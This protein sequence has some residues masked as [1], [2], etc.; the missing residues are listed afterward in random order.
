VYFNA[1]TVSLY[2]RFASKTL[3]LLL[4]AFHRQCQQLEPYFV[5]WPVTL[6]IDCRLE[7]PGLR[8]ALAANRLRH[9]RSRQ[10]PSLDL[11]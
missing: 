6:L 3:R 5:D 2:V 1:D 7:I 11:G 9:L 4:S 10:T 8:G